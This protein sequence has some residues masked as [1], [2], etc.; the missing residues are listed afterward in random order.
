MYATVWE[1][2]H[3]FNEIN[4]EIEPIT[5]QVLLLQKFVIIIIIKGDFCIITFSYIKAFWF[6]NVNNNLETKLNYSLRISMDSLIKLNKNFYINQ[7]RKSGCL[8]IMMRNR[9]FSLCL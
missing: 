3:R 4:N 5:L 2:I 6:P 8:T 1:R 9:R 7:F